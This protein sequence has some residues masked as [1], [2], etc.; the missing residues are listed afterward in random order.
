VLSLITNDAALSS[1]DKAEVEA[2]ASGFRGF[3]YALPAL[4]RFLTD[5]SGSISLLEETFQRAV[6][7]KILLNRSW[8]A[9][10]QHTEFA[11]RKPLLKNLRENIRKLYEQT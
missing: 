1:Q 10:L 3:D 5:Y 2:F 11:G 6:V 8:E 4:Q 9:V 7:E